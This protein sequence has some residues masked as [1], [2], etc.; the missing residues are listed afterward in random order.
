[1]S[2]LIEGIPG[3]SGNTFIALRQYI[4]TFGHDGKKGVVPYE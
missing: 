1:M 4:A 2:Q 3:F